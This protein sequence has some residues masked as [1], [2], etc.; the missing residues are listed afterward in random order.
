MY[1]TKAE[2]RILD[3]EL[4][5][6]KAKAMRILTILGD[7][8][9]ADKLIPIESVQVSGISYKT[10]GDAGL[11]FLEDWSD[12]QVIVETRM[13]PAGMDLTDW[14]KMGISEDFAIKQLRIIDGVLFFLNVNLIFLRF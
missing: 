14:K 7:I 12:N 1:L 13:N 6:I 3:G 5:E 4:G 9:E 2:E 11:E 10:I 8:F